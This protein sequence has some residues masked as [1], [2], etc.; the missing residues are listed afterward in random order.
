MIIQKIY[1]QSV[2]LIIN[3]VIL[4]IIGLSAFRVFFVPVKA[5]ETE[6]APSVVVFSE[7]FDSLT[8]PNLPVGWTTTNSGGSLPFATLSTFPDSPPNAI[9][10]N[11]PFVIGNSS[12]TTPSI[13]LGSVRHKLI[14]RQRY[15]L[16]F[17]FDGGVLEISINGGAFT[18][19]ISAGG[20]FVSGGYITPLVL[21]NKS[22]CSS[23]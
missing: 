6:F 18:D 12:L 21:S 2:F 23:D 17:E 4:A 19:I 13:T 11:D 15:Q 22:S 10:T 14:F 5:Q 20:S 3:L 1:R 7:N 16:D 8:T 9:Y